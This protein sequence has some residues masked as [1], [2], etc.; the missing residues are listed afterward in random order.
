MCNYERE[1]ALKKLVF[2]YYT[3][4][5]SGITCVTTERHSNGD[6]REDGWLITHSPQGP[7]CALEL[8]HVIPGTTFRNTGTQSN[9]T[10]RKTGST[11][12]QKSHI[13]HLFALLCVTTGI[14]HLGN[15]APLHH[16][17]DISLYWSTIP[18]PFLV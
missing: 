16:V 17:V 2:L 5:W 12:S 6:N 18:I 7:T 8:Q 3:W 14:I 15:P 9:H 13:I 4:R 1:V 11:L 10:C